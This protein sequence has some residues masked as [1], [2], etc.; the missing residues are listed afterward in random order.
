MKWYT[1]RL[2]ELA[3]AEPIYSVCGDDCAVC[4]RFVARTEDELRETAEFWFRAG[5]RDR[6]VSCEEI[7]CAGCGSR[8][9][10]SYMLLPC[11]REH[12]VTACASCG[13]FICD[14]IERMYANSE[15]K[16]RSCREA[17]DT[18]E[19]FAMLCRA[20]Y[21]KEKNMRRGQ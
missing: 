10:C 18:D 9:S 14:K 13:Q 16:K 2:S 1:D 15:E 20:F 11:A 3:G 5:W 7:K 6:V 12:N 19:E 4:P 8:P 17:C 21:N